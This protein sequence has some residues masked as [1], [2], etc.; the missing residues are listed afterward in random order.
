[1]ARLIT[2][3]ELSVREDGCEYIHGFVVK[4]VEKKV[5]GGGRNA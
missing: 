2:P 4:K 1:L 3:E 5:F